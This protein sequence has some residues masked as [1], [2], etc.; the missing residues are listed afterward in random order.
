MSK[1]LKGIGKIFKKIIKVV[2]KFA[3][4]I[5]AVGAIVLTGGAALGLALPSLGGVAGSL[6]L[7]AIAPAITA[8]GQGAL[9][10]AVGAAVQGKNILKGA[11]G[12]FVAGGVVG[13]LGQAFG[14][15]ANTAKSVTTGLDATTGAAS[16]GASAAG[17]AAPLVDAAPSVMSWNPGSV[18]SA[19]GGSGGGLGSALVST[20]PKVGGGLF[21]DPLVKG[22]LISGLGQGLLGYAQSKSETKAADKAWNR[23]AGSYTTDGLLAPTGIDYGAG[24]PTPAQKYDRWYVDPATGRVVS[25]G[26]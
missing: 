2:K 19:A 4:P 12:G 16:G 1:A 10:G 22:Q 3:L 17:A 24:R 26:A 5:L 13:G 11:T 25:T 15:V 23:A 7:G 6:G 21:S 14:A 18:A 20:A 9:F 8:A